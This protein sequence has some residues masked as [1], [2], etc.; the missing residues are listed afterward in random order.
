[1]DENT[2]PAAPA[3]PNPRWPALMGVLGSAVGAIALALF[4]WWLPARAAAGYRIPE[5]RGVVVRTP[6]LTLF[7]VRPWP[8]STVP[9]NATVTFDLSSGYTVSQQATPVGP[10]SWFSPRAD[11]V[12]LSLTPSF[13]RKSGLISKITVRWD[14][15]STDAH[16]SDLWA[17]H[18]FLSPQITGWARLPQNGGR[19]AIL[20]SYR[21]APDVV[22][23][24][25]PDP[26]M[27]PWQI[28]R[29]ADLP[30]DAQAVRGNSRLAAAAIPQLRRSICSDL[31]GNRAVVETGAPPPGAGYYV[32]QPVLEELSQGHAVTAAGRY[33]AMGSSVKPNAFNWW[34]FI[35]HSGGH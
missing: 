13:F 23:V 24:S 21:A 16:L 33:S 27:E 4:L 6:R 17:V 26:T 35:P 25:S 14:G 10:V 12:S 31:S 1:M 5:I 34:W 30:R 15:G 32:W 18:A 7:W 11:P 20:L 3:R 28:P 29:C 2:S 9:P 22:A 8:W 19:I